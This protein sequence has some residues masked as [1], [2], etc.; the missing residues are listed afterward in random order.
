MTT[1]LGGLP[2][3]PMTEQGFPGLPRFTT[4]WAGWFSTVQGILQDVSSSGTTAQRPTA[5]QYVSKH[6]FDT[7]LGKPIWLKTPGTSPVWVDAT[8]AVV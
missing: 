6:Y 3:L 2:M 7:T 1:P 8:G 4:P 5:N